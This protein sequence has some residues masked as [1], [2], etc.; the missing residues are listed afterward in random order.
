M[1]KRN[2]AD[3]DFAGDDAAEIG[4][5]CRIVIAGDPDPVAAR[6]QRRHGV[7]VRRGQPLMGGAIVKTV[8]E[9]DHHAGI[10][11]R[12]HGRKTAQRR[13]GVVRRQQHAARGKARAFFQM[14]IGNDEQVLLF[15][16][17]GAGGIGKQRDAGDIE[18]RRAQC[19]IIL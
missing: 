10:V 6:L 14:Q 15:P 13:R 7:A 9:R 19:P 4:R 3:A 17:Q 1:A 11:A 12:D 16:E 18:N 8:A 5:Q 2:R